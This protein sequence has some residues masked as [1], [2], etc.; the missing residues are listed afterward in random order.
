MR[1]AIRSI[2]A[3]LR[4]G[5]WL[6]PKRLRV[7]PALL[8]SF[9]AAAI[10][11]LVVTSDGHHDL[12]G[13]PLGTDFAQVWVAGSEVLSGHPE[14]P[15]DLPAHLSEQRT[16]F[17]PASDVYG[18]HYPPYFLALAA[19]LALIPY[20]AALAVWQLSTLPLYLASIRGALR[21]SR[22]PRWE[23]LVAGLAFPA[24]FINLTHGQNGF[25]TAGLFAGA[26]LCLEKRTWLA[27]VLFALLVYKPQFGFVIPVALIAG[28]YRRALLAGAA[29]LIGLTTVSF[30]EFGLQTWTAFQQ[31]LSF[32]RSVVLEDG[33]IGWEK[34]QSV[35]SAVRML[36]GSVAEAY[37]LQS[38][39]STFVIGA[40]AWL[41][42]SQSDTRLKYAALLSGALL[43]TPYCLDYDMVL[44]GPA[45]AF[46]VAYGLEHDFAPFEKTLLAAIWITPLVARLAGKLSYIPAGPVMM[47]TLFALIVVRASHERL[48]RSVGYLRWPKAR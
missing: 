14:R 15:Y 17:G 33:N 21:E 36:G 7:Y 35:F 41:W 8:L 5:S 16:F 4:S 25:L 47:V 45:I 28:G 34:I 24:V 20:A 11:V 23:V 37:A 12:L 26:L 19:L 9:Q 48:D 1:D 22:L 18:W 30:A 32:T 39:V 29:S 2:W 44:I 38:V 43:T 31:S 40:I 42:Y 46:L 6:T 13:R 27:G 10:L 3:S